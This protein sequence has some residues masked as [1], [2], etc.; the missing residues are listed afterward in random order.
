MTADRSGQG[1]SGHPIW[2][3][4]GEVNLAAVHVS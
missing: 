4:E 2:V 3:F 1:I